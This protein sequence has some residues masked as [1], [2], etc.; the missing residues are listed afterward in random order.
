MDCDVSRGEEVASV[1]SAITVSLPSRST[2][3][4]VW[5]VS[6]QESPC[7]VV[8]KC[9]VRPG[10][11]VEE[12]VGRDET[13]GEEAWVET[14]REGGVSERADG[15]GRGSRGGS[16]G[17]AGGEGLVVGVEGEVGGVE[18]GGGGREGLV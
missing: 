12:A 16:M 2:T 3:G 15:E 7:G 4:T 1:L 13:V 6:S 11:R 18:E 14:E 17:R 8:E 10:S 9:S 5:S